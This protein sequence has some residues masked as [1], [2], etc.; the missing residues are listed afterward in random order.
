[1]PVAKTKRTRVEGGRSYSRVTWQELSRHHTYW[2]TRPHA[3]QT[4]QSLS[5][6]NQESRIISTASQKTKLLSPETHKLQNMKLKNENTLQTTHLEPRNHNTITDPATKKGLKVPGLNH[7]TQMAVPG[8][9]K[10]TLVMRKETQH[11]TQTHT[12]L[13]NQKLHPQ[14]PAPKSSVVV[15]PTKL[16]SPLG[17]RVGT[18]PSPQATNKAQG[19]PKTS[20]IIQTTTTTTTTNNKLRYPPV[21]FKGDDNEGKRVPK[22]TH[23]Q[24]GPHDNKSNHSNLPQNNKSTPNN[25]NRNATQNRKTVTL[26]NNCGNPPTQ[27]SKSTLH[28]NIRNLSQNNKSVHNNDN[29]NRT[30]PLESKSVHPSHHPRQNPSILDHHHQNNNHN[31]RQSVSQP[32]KTQT[33]H[34][35][36]PPCTNRHSTHSSTTHTQS[37]LSHS[38]TQQQQSL[39][40]SSTHT[41]HQ[42][43]SRSSTHVN[44]HTTSGHRHQQ[45]TYSNNTTHHQHTYSNTITQR[46]HQQQ[47]RPISSSS[48]TSSASFTYP[49]NKSRFS[50]ARP[51]LDPNTGQSEWGIRRLKMRRV[52]LRDRFALY[53]LSSPERHPDDLTHNSRDKTRDTSADL[54]LRENGTSELDT[55]GNGLSS[56]DDGGGG[57]S[58]ESSENWVFKSGK[59]ENGIPV[60][61]TGVVQNESP[62]IGKSVN[63]APVPELGTPDSPSKIDVCDV[64]EGIGWGD[65]FKD[66]GDKGDKKVC[67]GGNNSEMCNGSSSRDGVVGEE[68]SGGGASGSEGKEKGCDSDSDDLSGSDYG[69]GIDSTV[70]V[71]GG[72]DKCGSDMDDKESEEGSNSDQNANSR[73]IDPNTT[74]DVTLDNYYGTSDD[75]DYSDDPFSGVETL[76]AEEM[77]D[78]MNS[79]TFLSSG[80][81]HL[82]DTETNLINGSEDFVNSESNQLKESDTFASNETNPL[83][84]SETFVNNETNPLRGNETFVSNETNPLRGSETFV[85]NETNPLRG[86]ETFVSNETNPLRGSETFVSNENN[87]LRGSETFVSNGSNMCSEVFKRSDTSSSTTSS[88]DE[89]SGCLWVSGVGMSVGEASSVVRSAVIVPTVKALTQTQREDSNTHSSSNS[90]NHSSLNNST[91]H[92]TFISDNNPSQYPCNKE[93]GNECNGESGCGVP[94]SPT[95]STHVTR[96]QSDEV[97]QNGVEECCE[98]ENE[99]YTTPRPLQQPTPRLPQQPTLHPVTKKRNS[100]DAPTSRPPPARSPPTTGRPGKGC[101]G[102]VEATQAEPLNTTKGARGGNSNNNNNSNNSNSSSS[103]G[104]KRG[105]TTLSS[106]TSSDDASRSKQQ[107]EETQHRG[108]A[109]KISLKD[110]PSRRSSG[111]NTPVS[112]TRSGS[113]GSGGASP[114]TLS[115]RVPHKT[116]TVAPAPSRPSNKALN[117]FG[118]RNNGKKATA[119][120]KSGESTDS[121]NSILSDAQTNSDSNS[122]IF[123][124]CD[125]D[126]KNSN[127]STDKICDSNGGSSELISN[128]NALKSVRVESP[129]VRHSKPVTTSSG[130]AKPGSTNN[131]QSGKI[132]AHTRQLPKPQIV[133]VKSFSPKS[134]GSQSQSP[135]HPSPAI[136]KSRSPSATPTPRDPTGSPSVRSLVQTPVKTSMDQASRVR[137]QVPGSS[138]SIPRISRDSES[139]TKSVLEADSGIGSSSESDRIRGE[140]AETDTIASSTIESTED[141]SD[142]WLRARQASQESVVKRQSKNFELNINGTE[143]D[144]KTQGQDMKGLTSLRSDSSNVSLKSESQSEKRAKF[145]KEKRESPI[146]YGMARQKFAPYS[147]NRYGYGYQSG[148]GRSNS[149]DSTSSSSTTTTTNTTTPQSNTRSKVSGSSG[150]VRNRVALLETTPGK[151]A[152]PPTP[153]LRKSNIKKPAI[154]PTSLEKTPLLVMPVTEQTVELSKPVCRKLEYSEG[155]TVFG[156]DRDDTKADDA[157]QG[158]NAKVSNGSKTVAEDI[159]IV[160][161]IETEMQ[162]DNNILV[163]TEN[164]GSYYENIY[165]QRIIEKSESSPKVSPGSELQTSYTKAREDLN[166]TEK[167]SGKQ[168]TSDM[169]CSSSAVGSPVDITE[170][171]DT[172][173][174]LHSP[175]DLGLKAITPQSESSFEILESLSETIDL[176]I[177]EIKEDCEASI[178]ISES[179]STISESK[180]H[181]KV[182]SPVPAVSEASVKPAVPPKPKNAVTPTQTSVPHQDTANTVEVHH[183]QPPDTPRSQTGTTDKQPVSS[184]LD[185]KRQLGQMLASMKSSLESKSSMESSIESQNSLA[186]G[187]PMVE[188]GELTSTLSGM[189]T[190]LL[191]SKGDMDQDFLI[192]DEI[193]DQPG[194]LFA[195]P[196]LSSSFFGDDGIFDDM[197]TATPS[198]AALKAVMELERSRADSVDT[199]SSLG[200]DDLML[201]FEDTKMAATGG[202]PPNTPTTTTSPQP[203]PETGARAKRTRLRIAIP[204]PRYEEEVLSPDASEIFSEWTAMMAEMGGS[205]RCVSRDGSSCGGR[206][207][208]TRQGSLTETSSS[209]DPRRPTVLRPPRQGG[210]C[211][212]EGGGVYVD[213]TSYQYLRQEARA[214]KTMLLQLRRIIQGAD[215]INPF[216]TNMRNSLYLSLGSSG[217]SEVA[218][219]V[220]GEKDSLGQTVTEI[221]HENVDLRRQVVLLQ[222]QLEEKDR[223]IRLLQQQL[224]QSLQLSPAPTS[225]GTTTDNPE[226][227]RSLNAATQTDRSTRTTLMGLHSSSFDDGAG[228]T[229]SSEMDG[230]RCGRS[231]SV[232]LQGHSRLRQPRAASQP[233]ATIQPPVTPAHT[234][235]SSG[236]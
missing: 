196:G 77:D 189:C 203:E 109:V 64:I 173:S 205:E 98:G 171:L 52:R 43:L 220:A 177:E 93:S 31:Y 71:A 12:E 51:H 18:R 40:R 176:T 53:P 10:K 139:S 97:V 155:T 58:T 29:H 86:N 181:V 168:G 128:D 102:R 199:T 133:T 235:Q 104:S 130:L 229:V 54:A 66:S 141:M 193:S 125:E 107:R 118:F 156:D 106:G 70:D 36:Q 132:T 69:S 231:R 100:I 85:N 175:D 223:T 21:A 162:K 127:D 110:D 187:N 90:T 210:V 159:L 80:I 6:E 158:L 217:G 96:I 2:E 46:H 92:S 42:N 87:F 78:M 226:A 131:Q 61:K 116:A 15:V 32:V 72:S 148:V 26:Q 153:A 38:H 126:E 185:K 221:S 188:S 161:S 202:W 111:L 73:I 190:P 184:P 183:T 234:H 59:S 147:R 157:F 227:T 137:Q 3:H 57:V 5:T 236:S 14:V 19:I 169:S 9:Q 48:S 101:G 30:S 186:L 232:S 228:P 24:F 160:G 74:H 138:H 178:S 88:S 194:L 108:R 34:K 144:L 95:R 20:L 124:L 60:L 207:P 1:M 44:T 39:A 233:P 140:A 215:T 212:V 22:T 50:S 114:A 83:R 170:E 81:S 208:R 8:R 135:R 206:T 115:N 150:L 222:Q 47:P 35:I 41:H 112:R 149:T 200:G 224:S 225:T 91:T 198:H 67:S 94:C 166:Q 123:E 55:S 201:D 37:I 180:P 218:G 63:G 209:P 23:Q 65:V 11:S 219:R 45:H 214:L 213:R 167:S 7:N 120:V 113:R 197:P 143:I 164:Y 75:E 154:R 211:E 216:D 134:H 103:S 230:E 79:E 119:T 192:D 121:V 145:G 152:S 142:A 16:R 172:K 151:K 182:E 105:A 17:A 146:T 49:P 136:S 179:R 99:R 82:S 163:E 33:H 28:N 56:D 89:E 13:G 68:D 4:T 195:G 27:N 62:E 191:T 84:G 25:Y 204:G 174:E 76:S 122:N 129:L 165:D 117:R